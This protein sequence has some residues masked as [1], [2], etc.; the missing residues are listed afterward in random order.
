MWPRIQ[1]TCWHLYNDEM[2][3]PPIPRRPDASYP[4]LGM[5]VI[6]DCHPGAFIST[7][8]FVLGFVLGPE[9]ANQV[10]CRVLLRWGP[11]LLAS[12]AFAF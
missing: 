6:R 8:V 11:E 2:K 7:N 3:C 12:T 10:P 1:T 4:C 5:A 9:R